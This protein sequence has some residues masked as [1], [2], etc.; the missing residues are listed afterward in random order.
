MLFLNLYLLSFQ[1]EDLS[2]AHVYLRLEKGQRLEDISPD[3]VMECAQ[4]VKANS[5]EGCKLK[6]VT[7]IYTRWRNLHKTSDMQVGAIGYHDRSKVKSVRVVKDNTIVNRI[8]RTKE[9]ISNVFCKCF[10]IIQSFLGAISKSFRIAR[11]TSGRASFRI[12]AAKER[13]A[14]AGET[15]ATGEGG[16]CKAEKLRVSY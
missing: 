12:K 2:S 7:V 10:F 1:V 8:N 3:I 15:A 5:I 16:G 11:S 6:E 14:F 9:V 4:L 13:S